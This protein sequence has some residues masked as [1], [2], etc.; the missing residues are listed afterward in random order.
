MKENVTI[1][2]KLAYRVKC[3]KNCILFPKVVYHFDPKIK[4]IYYETGI[5]LVTK[6]VFSEALNRFGFF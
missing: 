5:I 6:S 1:C 2:L 3:L 4:K